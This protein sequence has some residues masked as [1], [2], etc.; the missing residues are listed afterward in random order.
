MRDLTLMVLGDERSPVRRFYIPE[1]K[2]RRSIA[3]VALVVSLT[4]LGIW[5]YLRLQGGRSELSSLRIEAAEQ[6]E[7]I[8]MFEET[9]GSVQTELERV[10]QLERKVRIIA[11][12]PGAAATGGAEVTEMA[13]RATGGLPVLDH[14]SMP[15]VGLPIEFGGEINAGDLPASIPHSQMQLPLNRQLDS[16]QGE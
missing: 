1:H 12:L 15:A 9:L 2:M 13:P 3:L 7:Q 8:K 11:N 5:D 14:R 16:D 6:R 4:V 10:R